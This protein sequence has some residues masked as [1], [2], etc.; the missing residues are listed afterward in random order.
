MAGDVAGPPALGHTPGSE[1]ERGPWSTSLG[2]RQLC[3]LGRPERVS[4]A[5]E[6]RLCPIHTTACVKPNQGQSTRLTRLE[7]SGFENPDC[8]PYSAVVETVVFFSEIKN[9]AAKSMQLTGHPFRHLLKSLNKWLSFEPC[10]QSNVQNK[11]HAG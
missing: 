8:P 7:C 4:R 11:K 2:A 9:V 6:A 10:A 5:E 3:E 1:P